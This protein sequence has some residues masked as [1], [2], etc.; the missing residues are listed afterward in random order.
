MRFYARFVALCNICFI[1]SVIL[2][3]VEMN[4][5]VKGNFDGAIKFQPLESTLVILGYTAIIFNFFFVIIM[6]GRLMRKPRILLPR[7]LV[8]FNLMMFPLEVYYLLF[9]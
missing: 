8:W 9:T 4:R 2:R 1:I 6:F 3:L 5:R 7:W